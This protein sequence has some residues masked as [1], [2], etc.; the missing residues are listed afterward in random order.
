MEEKVGPATEIERRYLG[1]RG[2]ERYTGLSR[3][4]LA[5]AR[6]RGELPAVRVGAAVRF[7]VEDLD[8]FM[9]ARRA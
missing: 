5:R 4:T 9:R 2:A 3:W 7:S 8:S 6:E 1:F